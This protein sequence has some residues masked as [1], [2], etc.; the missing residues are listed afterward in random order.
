M[1]PLIKTFVPRD[2]AMS[3]KCPRQVSAA[4]QACIQKISASFAALLASIGWKINM[5]SS[6]EVIHSY[7]KLIE[8]SAFY[9]YCSLAGKQHAFQKASNPLSADK[10]K[11]KPGW[12]NYLIYRS[13]I[14]YLKFTIQCCSA[15]LPYISA[16]W[17]VQWQQLLN[18]DIGDKKRV[19]EHI[20][21]LCMHQSSN[22]TL[23]MSG[24]NLSQVNR[25]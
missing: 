18:S 25:I 7:I 1:K 19:L 24:N 15:A 12:I 13:S 14:S 8:C 20:T 9:R 10:Y 6:L 3:L 4:Q 16:A 11:L 17:T 23:L 2:K 22:T 5:F 21:F